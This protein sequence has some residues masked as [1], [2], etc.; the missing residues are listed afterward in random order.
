MEFLWVFILI[1][2]YNN[3]QVYEL[4]LETNTRAKCEKGREEI[5]QMVQKDPRTES[6]IA[7]W[8]VTPCKPKKSEVVRD[9]HD[10]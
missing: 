9:R 5:A 7:F 1:V 10:F 4:V 3:G 2:G 8:S 6:E